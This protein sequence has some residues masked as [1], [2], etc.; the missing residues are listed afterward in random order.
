L[1]F[2]T[3]NVKYRNKRWIQQD[4]FDLFI[5]GENNSYFNRLQIKGKSKHCEDIKT[6]SHLLRYLVLLHLTDLTK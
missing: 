4:K 2:F 6:D 3:E 5:N 1:N